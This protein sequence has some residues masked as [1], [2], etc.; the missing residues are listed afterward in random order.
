[1][2][3]G[4]GVHKSGCGSAML[5]SVYFYSLAVNDKAKNRTQYQLSTAYKKAE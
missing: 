4:L 5:I 1:M 3:S 2:R